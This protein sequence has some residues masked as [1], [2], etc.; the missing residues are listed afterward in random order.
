MDHGSNFFIAMFHSSMDKNMVLGNRFWFFFGS[1][2]SLVKWAPNF[3]MNDSTCTLVLFW[4]EMPALP[5]EY[6]YMDIVE[7]IANKFGSFIQHDLHPFEEPYHSIHVFLLLDTS[8][9]LPQSIL[10]NLIG[11]SGNKTLLFKMHKLSPFMLIFWVILQINVKMQTVQSWLFA[12]N[13]LSF[14]LN[15][16][17]W[18]KWVTLLHPPLQI[19]CLILMPITSQMGIFHW[20]IWVM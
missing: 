11:V 17:W 8:K 10:F 5:I 1:G 19:H 3:E 6:R 20:I 2:I 12:K 16:L 15:A 9:P 7:A 4:I 13:T 14:P 18:P